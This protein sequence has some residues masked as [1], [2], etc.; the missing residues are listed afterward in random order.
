[1]G[2]AMIHRGPDDSGTLIDGGLA[3]GMRRLSIIDLSGGHQPIA[4]ED[5]T[6]HV[7]CNGE[8]YNYRELSQQLKARGHRFKTASDSEVLLHLYE[9]YGPE[10]ISRLDGMYGFALWDSRTRSLLIGRD[11][12]GI[13]PL[14]YYVD[15]KRI[16]FA[17]EIKSLLALPFVDRSIDQGA[18][19]EY[20]AL[21]YV[22]APLTLFSGIRKLPPASLMIC[23]PGKVDIRQ[24]WS[25]PTEAETRSEGDW[26]EAVIESLER[27]VASQMVSD[28]PIGAFLSGGID[29]SAVVAMMSRNSDQP[30][31]TYSIGFDDS[32]AGSFYNELPYA[33]KVAELFA[34]EHHEILVRPD[35]VKLLPKLLWHLDEPMSDSAFITTFLISEFASRDVKVILS[36]VGGDELFG[37]YRRYLGEYYAALYSRV[38]AWI[39]RQVINPLARRLPSDR[40]SPLLN[41]S[42][43]ARSFVMSHEDSFEDRYRS[44]IEVFDSESSRAL[45]LNQNGS[46]ADAIHRAFCAANAQGGDYLKRLLEVDCATQLPDD[47]LLLT[48]KMSM[49]V[50]LECRVPLLDT[51]LVELASKMPADC[52]IRNREL[53]HVLKK[54]L[55]DVLPR[56]IL[57]R[58]KRGFGAPLGAWIRNELRNTVGTVLSRSAVEARGLLSWPA[59]ERTIALH[60]AKKEDH[61]DHLLS[62]L[63]LELWLRLYVDGVPYGDLAEELEE[64]TP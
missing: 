64:A 35:V 46:D 55:G 53:K 54:A 18:V 15:D 36:G 30:I 21:G 2:N 50:S 28:V 49:A 39:R 29:S 33:R 43:L 31:Q 9:D 1:M 7:V 22:P 48:D 42:R 63:N 60:N 38:P 11:R 16:A 6:I 61:T 37:G 20:L 41:L 23:T 56:D 25:L 26:A 51:S 19:S 3:L 32:S 17:S 44:Y 62:L 10:F 59:V 4:N 47:L 14:Y 5:G 34:T 12:V 45:L 27:S 58:S 52:K 40:H 13:K 24:Y 8:I 57:Y